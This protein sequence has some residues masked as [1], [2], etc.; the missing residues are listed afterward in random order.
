MQSILLFKAYFAKIPLPTH[1]KKKLLEIIKVAT[2][3]VSDNEIFSFLTIDIHYRTLTKYFHVIA[4]L[5]RKKKIVK[6]RMFVLETEIQKC[7][8]FFYCSFLACKFGT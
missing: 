7:F 8:N 2:S 6:I 1:R 4:L 5:Q 3:N